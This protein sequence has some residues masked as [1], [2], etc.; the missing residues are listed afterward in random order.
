M[1]GAGSDGAGGELRA[2][3]HPLH[4]MLE[5]V[6][7]KFRAVLEQNERYVISY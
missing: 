6:K 1:E 7:A 3:E 5:N 2:A 4:F